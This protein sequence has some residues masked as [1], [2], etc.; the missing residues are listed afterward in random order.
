MPACCEG[1]KDQYEKFK[2]QFNYSCSLER[3]FLKR[4]NSSA[5]M[6][7]ETANCLEY[8]SMALRD[9][10]A[11]YVY[12]PQYKIDTYRAFELYT[13]SF[14]CRTYKVDYQAAFANK[15][16]DFVVENQKWILD[17]KYKINYCDARL[18]EIKDA[19]Q[20]IKYILYKNMKDYLGIILYPSLS[21]IKTAD[22]IA[23]KVVAIDKEKERLVKIGIALPMKKHK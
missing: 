21:G 23:Q 14:L 17:A 16:P 19:S 2:I 1:L 20:L 4:L 6:K 7:E 18:I 11:G 15:Y 12:I 3:P 5:S 13:Y 22:K 10:D 9:I 8:L